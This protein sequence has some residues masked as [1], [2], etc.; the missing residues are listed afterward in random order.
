MIKLTLLKPSYRENGWPVNEVFFQHLSEYEKSFVELELGGTRTLDFYMS[1]LKVLG[2][3]NKDS[4]LDAGCGI[5]QWGIALA[6]LNEKV[7]GLDRDKNRICFANELI[8]TMGIDN[9]S[10]HIGSLEYLPFEN[11]RFDAIFCYGVFMFAHTKMALYEFNRVLRSEGMLYL[12]FNSLGWY[13]HLILDRGIKKLNLNMVLQSLKMVSR[14]FLG[15]KQQILIRERWL[16]QQLVQ[17][18]FGSIQVASEGDLCPKLEPNQLKP[19]SLYR[20]HY[21]GMRA[22]VEVL[23]KKEN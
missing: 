17:A 3:A 22:V 23:C 2:F 4:V 15:F 20:S 1:R 13:A 11:Q 7:E 16:T 18:G 14:Y 21:Y 12:N 10:T 19:K 8:K 9:F 6:Q 5:G